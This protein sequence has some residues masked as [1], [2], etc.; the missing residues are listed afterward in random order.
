MN[1]ANTFA[2][3]MTIVFNALVLAPSLT[4][5]GTA[6][7]VMFRTDATKLSPQWAEVY[8]TWL[9]RIDFLA[10][11]A[12]ISCVK[13]RRDSGKVPE[14][15]VA[16]SVAID[17]ALDTAKCE[18]QRELVLAEIDQE[19]SGRQCQALQKSLKHAT[20][21]LKSADRKC[22]MVEIERLRFETEA[23]KVKIRKLAGIPPAN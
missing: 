13:L 14:A 21:A 19:S 5:A 22:A 2:I 16:V 4:K 11:R 20:T 9:K 18:V 23:M 17:V 8:S 10:D 15:K 6:G 3:T 7:D 12:F 1:G